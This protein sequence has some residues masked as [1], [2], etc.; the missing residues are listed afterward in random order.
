MP[1][2]TPPAT[3]RRHRPPH[4]GDNGSGRR[5]P[6]DKRTGGNG[7]GDN[8]NWDARSNSRRS[9]RE[10]IARARVGL[11]IALGGVVMF[12]TA[13]VSAFLLG[14]SSGHV[15]HYGRYINDWHPIVL[16]RILLLNTAILAL[17]S[18]TAELARRSMFRESDVMDEWIGLG[19]PTSNRA[20]AW[21]AATLLLGL[22]FL[23]GQFRAWSQIAAARNA[24]LTTS[25]RHYF[26]LITGTHAAHITFG[27][28][29]LIATLTLLQR[30]RSIATRQVFV[31]ATVVYWHAMGALWLILYALL[32]F[33]Q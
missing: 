5:P 1:I 27:I 33:G 13:I 19:R 8:D 11:I 32:E 16:P 4:E 6:T 3:E 28:L 21:L 18:V 30:S 7:D 14:K 10:R 22:A 15:N 26:N 31:D 17:S 24:F 29:A 12:F 23:S 25:A 20:T 9:P 2:L